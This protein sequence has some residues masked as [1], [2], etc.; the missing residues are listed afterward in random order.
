MQQIKYLNLE[1]LKKS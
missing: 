1:M